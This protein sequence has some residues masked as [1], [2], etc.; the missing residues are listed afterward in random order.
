[1]K[2]AWK[3]KGY[4]CAATTDCDVEENEF[5]HATKTVRILYR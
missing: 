3:G 5:H 2:E 4:I 1:M